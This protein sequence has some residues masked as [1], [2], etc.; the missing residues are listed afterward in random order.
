MG[1][2]M[3]H[4]WWSASLASID[5]SGPCSI[6][7]V[8]P[9]ASV[10]EKPVASLHARLTARMRHGRE[11]SVATHAMALKRG[12]ASRICWRGPSP[13][14]IPAGLAKTLETCVDTMDSDASAEWFLGM[15]GTAP[16]EAGSNEMG[17]RSGT[18]R[19][20]AAR[21]VPD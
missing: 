18:K 12:S 2:C 19:S 5:V 21:V 1:E 14:R 13:R 17:R 11:G 20:V 16:P 9:T 8:F 3:V 4:A 15:I 7:H 10:A 6:R